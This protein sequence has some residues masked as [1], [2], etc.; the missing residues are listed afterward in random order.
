M[1]GALIK[2]NRLDA[3]DIHFNSHG[4]KI[5]VEWF[6]LK[7]KTDKQHT[8]WHT[9]TN[10]EIHYLLEG[11]LCIETAQKTLHIG[12]GEALII[13]PDMPHRLRITSD[14]YHLRF[15]INCSVSA[16]GT[17]PDSVGLVTRLGSPLL[18]PVKLSPYARQIMLHSLD[19]SAAGAFGFSSIV[20]ANLVNFLFLLGRKLENGGKEVKDI[21]AKTKKTLQDLRMESILAYLSQHVY[22]P[23]NVVE[24]AE[25][26]N[27]S[28]SQLER[29]IKY[30]RGE[31]PLR[32]IQL[33]KMEKAR[34][35]LKDPMLSVGDIANMLGFPNEYDFNRTFKRIEGMPPGKYRVGL[36]QK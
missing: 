35:L 9:H 1:D 36:C 14:Q 18:R 2:G 20:E 3:L 4:L 34:E 25:N 32:M 27:L 24:L 11:A 33:V 10:L 19:E 12:E 13:P 17:H 31:T 5:D 26:M 15:V 21:Q 23:L 8:F 28:M 16:T 6:R 22:E 30:C 7:W 29:T